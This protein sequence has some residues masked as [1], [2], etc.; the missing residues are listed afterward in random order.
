MHTC[1]FFYFRVVG[2]VIGIL[3]LW[4]FGADCAEVILLA[5]LVVEVDVA[6]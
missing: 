1:H 3:D 6:T 2:R 5:F 4:V